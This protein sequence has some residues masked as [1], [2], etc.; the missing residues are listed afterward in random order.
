MKQ[1]KIPMKKIKSIFPYIIILILSLVIAYLKGCSPKTKGDQIEISGKKYEVIKKEI[2]T[3][4]RVK[5]KIEYKRGK[6]IYHTIEKIIEVPSKVDTTS[7]LKDYYAKNIYLDTFIL[8]DSI[9]YVAINDT[10]SM[11]KIQ[12]RIFTSSI[13]LPTIRETIYLKE[14]SN[15][16]FFGPSTQL[17]RIV[18][19]GGDVH[20]K[21]KKDYLIGLGAGISTGLDPYV[22]GS[23]GWKIK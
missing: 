6:D 14:I 9:G 8:N 2:D 13:N 7:I 4:Y 1:K 16:W 18:Y 5:E 21:T 23:F 12:G 10:I 11:N 3:L 22:R 20:L 19:L 15:S 17:G